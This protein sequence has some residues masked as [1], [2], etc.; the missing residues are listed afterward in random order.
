MTFFVIHRMIERMRHCRDQLMS[1][2]PRQHG[3]AVESDNVFHLTQ[4]RLRAAFGQRERLAFI[5]QPAVK[6]IQFAA[7]TLIPHPH[8]LFLIEF[9][10]AVQQRKQCALRRGITAVQHL[11]LLH[12]KGQQGIVIRILRI[13]AV[14]KI[15][16]Q[17]EIQVR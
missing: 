15:T 7:L 6:R 17:R 4:M 8:A 3:I 16:E 14:M 1:G 9:A 10:V 5:A 12:G 11:N 2:G 13:Y